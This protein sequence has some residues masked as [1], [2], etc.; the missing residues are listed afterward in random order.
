[1]NTYDFFSFNVYDRN[2]RRYIAVFDFRKTRYGGRSVYGTRRFHEIRAGKR[3]AI[4]DVTQVG[5]IA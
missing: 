5:E 1:M 4:D 3:A 2:C